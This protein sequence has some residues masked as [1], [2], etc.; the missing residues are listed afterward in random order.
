M[1]LWPSGVGGAVTSLQLQVDPSRVLCSPTFGTDS[2][3]WYSLVVRK[4]VTLCLRVLNVRI[5]FFFNICLPLIKQNGKKYFLYQ[6]DLFGEYMKSSLFVY[7]LYENFPISAG[8]MVFTVP[9]IYY[10]QGNE[11]RKTCLKSSTQHFSGL[12]AYDKFFFP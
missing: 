11:R 10:Q 6:L 8:K 7:K 12:H 3:R 9:D 2:S 5:F 1:T 4:Q